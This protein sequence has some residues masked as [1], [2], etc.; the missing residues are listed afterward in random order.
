MSWPS[1]S[2]SEMRKLVR[3]RADM[4]PS[5]FVTD[6]EVDQYITEAAGELHSLLISVRG[7]LFQ[8]TAS[9]TTTANEA[10]VEIVSDVYQLASVRYELDGYEYPLQRWNA[11]RVL[12]SLSHNWG[13]TYTPRYRYTMRVVDGATRHFLRFDPPPSTAV[14]INYDY[15]P[16][17]ETYENDDDVIAL[18]WPEYVLLGAAI[19]CLQK[20][21]VDS[22]D[23]AANQAVLVQ[24][25]E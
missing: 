20:E 3:Q 6:S 11:S 17:P 8:E 1:Y 22:S 2:L 12:R 14:T 10:E 16:S 4:D 7:D 24:R 18:P 5:D 19:R 9:V 21:K 23:L 13:Y 15:I 25:I